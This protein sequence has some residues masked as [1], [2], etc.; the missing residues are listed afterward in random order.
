MYGFGLFNPPL[1]S[2][3]VYEAAESNTEFTLDEAVSSISGAYFGLSS[4]T[5]SMGQAIS[6]LIIGFILTGA[7]AENSTIITLTLSFM[8]V[9]YLISLYFLRK[10]KL[11]T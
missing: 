1:A 9:F 2:A 4:F 3:L 5:L 10:L 6:S 7:N 11:K 8:G